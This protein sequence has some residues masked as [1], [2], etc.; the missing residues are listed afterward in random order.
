MLLVTGQAFHALST[1][2]NPVD[3]S[4]LKIRH[5][6]NA[7]KHLNSAPF[8]PR[9]SALTPSTFAPCPP[10]GRTSRSTSWRPPR[11]TRTRPSG[12][13]ARRP[14]YHRAPFLTGAP[15]PCTPKF[16]NCSFAIDNDEEDANIFS[17]WHSKSPSQFC[18][19]VNYMTQKL[20]GCHCT[21]KQQPNAPLQDSGGVAYRYGG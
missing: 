14:G 10:S 16:M 12:S 7:T 1:S 17:I 21:L 3:T 15:R 8:E 4:P 5:G 13:S 2:Q 9:P 19:E 6:L 18:L 11:T 20:R